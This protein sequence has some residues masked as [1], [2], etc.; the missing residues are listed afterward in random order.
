MWHGH[1]SSLGGAIEE[2]AKKVKKMKKSQASKKTGESLRQEVKKLAVAG[3]LPFD[4][5]MVTGPSVPAD[6]AAPSAEASAS[7]SDKPDLTAPIAEEM[8]QL[9]TNPVVPQ[10]GDDD[11]QLEETEGGDA[12]SHPETT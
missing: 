5:L 10:L 2:L 6:Q 12:V 1:S 3:D 7:Q 8:F 11:I 4:L 9:L